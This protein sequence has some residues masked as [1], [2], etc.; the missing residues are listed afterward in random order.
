MAIG[1]KTKKLWQ[2]PKY[3]Q[4]MKDAHKDQKKSPTGY[5]FPKGESNPAK[6]TDVR[7]KIGHALRG[8]KPTRLGAKWSD[9]Q[10]RK[11]SEATSGSK[12]YRWKGGYTQN[13]KN[14]HEKR[15]RI[16]KKGNQGSH[17]LGEWENIKS[18]YNQTC[19]RC[20][21]A[22]PE[23]KLTEDH[24]IPI[25]KGGSDNIENI[26]PLC[27]SCNSKKHTKVIIYEKN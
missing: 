24:I 21:K 17:T 23:I 22:E 2:Q 15:R 8:R 1:E 3:R 5:T 14:F 10:K 9:N 16:R 26:Q 11:F 25:S 6:R 27:R 12:H 18:Q 4:H 7:K 20:H 13:D 19:P